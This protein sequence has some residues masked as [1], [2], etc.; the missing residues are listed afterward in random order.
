V[1][2]KV[3]VLPLANAAEITIWPGSIAMG[4][5][6][7]IDMRAPSLGRFAVRYSKPPRV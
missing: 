4:T 5:P 6:L 1:R 2:K 3:G 7:P